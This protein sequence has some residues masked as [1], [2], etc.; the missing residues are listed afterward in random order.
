VLS[1]IVLDKK[2]TLKIEKY[3]KNII[4]NFKF[5]GLAGFDFLLTANEC[6]LLE[7]NPRPTATVELFERMPPHRNL[8]YK[9]IQACTGAVSN[10]AHRSP[11]RRIVG[12]RVVYASNGLQIPAG[13][14][15]PLWAAD[16]PHSG[17]RIPRGSPVCSVFADGN[18]EDLVQRE[19][20]KRS[21]TIEDLLQQ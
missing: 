16:I 1:G 4:K 12:T 6:Y 2:N 13:F 9:H 11:S 20:A 17:D 10:R 5:C 8:L 15:W 7:I 21:Q 19:L 3:I 14:T 18:E